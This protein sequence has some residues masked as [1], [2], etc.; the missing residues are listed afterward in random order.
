MIGAIIGNIA[1]AQYAVP[2]VM[3][4]RTKCYLLQDMLEVVSKFEKQKL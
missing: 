4:D 2:T 3:A 1:D